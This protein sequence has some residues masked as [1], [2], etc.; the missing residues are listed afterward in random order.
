MREA[1]MPDPP[2]GAPLMSPLECFLPRSR[3]MEDRRMRRCR[4][5]PPEGMSGCP[6]APATDVEDPRRELELLPS[7]TSPRLGEERANRLFC[8]SRVRL[9]HDVHGP[10]RCSPASSSRISSFYPRN[11]LCAN[12]FS[13]SL[14]LFYSSC[15]KSV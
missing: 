11:N 14:Q 3:S 9:T 10:G 7:L 15:S 5:V 12:S 2:G 1:S 8:F 13:P 4:P 6:T